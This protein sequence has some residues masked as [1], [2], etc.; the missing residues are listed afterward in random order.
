MLEV[1]RDALLT[2]NEVKYDRCRR[3]EEY[4]GV[5]RSAV[6]GIGMRMFQCVG[7]KMLSETG[8]GSEE[9]GRN[10]RQGA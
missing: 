6:D 3:R 5:G 9:S 1:P 8:R 4:G 2:D 7:I 10:N